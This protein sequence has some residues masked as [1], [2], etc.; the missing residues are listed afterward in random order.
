MTA[1][2]MREWHY[3]Q[4]IEGLRMLLPE[5]ATFDIGDF[6]RDGGLDALA[7]LN[8]DERQAVRVA[9]QFMRCDE[10]AKQI[11]REIGGP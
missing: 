2:G 3:E 6:G 5:F 7:D 9:L 4:I 1:N 8:E 11:F 10:A